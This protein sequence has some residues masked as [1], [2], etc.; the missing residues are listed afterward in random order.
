MLSSHHRGESWTL[1]R[2]SCSANLSAADDF[3]AFFDARRSALLG[4]IGD[5]MGKE[6]TDVPAEQPA[7]ADDYDLDDEEPS[8]DDVEEAVA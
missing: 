4:L 3:D 6:I 2:N 5:D 1:S 8:D 7:V